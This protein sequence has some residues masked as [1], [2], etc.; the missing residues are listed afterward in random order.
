MTRSKSIIEQRSLKVILKN[1]FHSFLV[2]IA[3]ALV[4]LPLIYG[5]SRVQWHTVNEEDTSFGVN[6]KNFQLSLILQAAFPLSIYSIALYAC[7]N[8][9][10]RIPKA[11]LLTVTGVF[12][13]AIIASVLFWHYNVK[14]WFYY[15]DLVSH[16]HC[17]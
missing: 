15:G 1:Y 5:L 3:I 16:R 14:L 12:T 4:N 13:I 10:L 6:V 7:M 9:T 8:Q 17:M 2:S 11:L